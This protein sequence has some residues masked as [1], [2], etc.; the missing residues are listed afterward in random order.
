M[1]NVF[2]DVQLLA[3]CKDFYAYVHICLILYDCFEEATNNHVFDDI[4][5]V[6]SKHFSGTAAAEDIH[7]EFLAVG[8]WSWTSELLEDT[9]H[10][11]KKSQLYVRCIYIRSWAHDYAHCFYSWNVTVSQVSKTLRKIIQNSWFPFLIS[12]CCGMASCL[13]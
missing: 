6:F 4:F 9:K 11:Q 8:M 10:L 13:L 1:S 7:E 12:D 5:S 2:N 3:F